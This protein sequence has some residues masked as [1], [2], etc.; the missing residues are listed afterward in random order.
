[1]P[2]AS[3]VSTASG[4]EIIDAKPH[5]TSVQVALNTGGGS[6]GAAGKMRRLRCP[7]WAHSCVVSFWD[8]STTPWTPAQGWVFQEGSNLTLVDDSTIPGDSAPV[9]AAAAVGFACSPNGFDVASKR[10]RGHDLGLGADSVAN[11]VAVIEFRA[12]PSEGV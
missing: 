10:P 7:W 1:M 3:V 11:A 5:E 2:A 6:L 9:P 4:L 12:A 8:P